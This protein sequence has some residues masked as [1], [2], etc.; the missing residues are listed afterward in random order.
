MRNLK[1]VNGSLW[2]LLFLLLMNFH[3]LKYGL[4]DFV[5][6]KGPLPMT[7]K[8]FTASALDQQVMLTWDAHEGI[9][10][11]LYHS[12][13]PGI[14]VNDKNAMKMSDVTSPYIHKELMHDTIYYYRL[15]AVN[16]VGASE[17]TEEISATT[18]GPG[19]PPPAPQN[20]MA[21]VSSGQVILTWDSL[22]S[23]TYDI[24]HSTNAGF[25]LASG[26]K[27]TNV[28]QPYTHTGLTNGTTYYYRLTATNASGTSPPTAEV[29]ATPLA[30]PQN[31]ATSAS[32]GQVMLTWDSLPGINY[33]I[34]HS[35]NA[36]FALASG[37]KITNAPQPYNHTGLTNGTTY[38][39]RLTATSASSTSPPTAEVSATPLA[40]PQNFTAAAS[41]GQVTLAWTEQ[42]GVTYDLYHST[43]TGFALANGIKVANAPQPYTHTGLT[44]GT[45]Y[46]YRLTATNAS[47][48]S[49]PTAE[50][51]AIPL[52][53]PQ[54]FAASASTG[55]VTLTWDSLP[56]VSYDLYHL[57]MS[58]FALV[59]G[60]KVANAPQPYTHTGLTNGTTYYYKL[61]VTSTLGTSSPTAEVSAT[62][63]AVPQNFAARPSLPGQI[64]L[65]WTEKEGVTYDLYHS[66]TAEFD[67][68][69]GI[70]IPNVPQP[71]TH[72]GLTDRTTYYYL[73]TAVNNSGTST[74]TA[75][76]SAPS[77]GVQKIS[78]GGKHTCAVIS[79]GFAEC[80]GEADSGRL[81]DNQSSS[82]RDSPVRVLGN[83]AAT[84][85]GFTQISAGEEHTCAV[86][87]GGAMCWGKGTSGRIGNSLTVNR[88][89]PVKTGLTS[90]V[91]RISAGGSHSCAVVNG[92]AMCWGLNDSGQLGN[93]MTGTAGSTSPVEV[94]DNTNTAITGVTQISAGD[95]HTCAVVNNKAWCWGEGDEGRLGNGQ[96]DDMN[97]PVLV[98]G[99]LGNVTQISAG[100]SH[101]CVVV[102]GRARCWGGGLRGQLGKGGDGA[103]LD[104]S[105]PVLVA[106]LTSGVTR[107]SAGGEHTCAV[108]NGRALCWGRGAGGQ[109][110]NGGTGGSET[111]VQV[112]GLTS[113]V[114]EI[115]AGNNHT[116]AVMNGRA[117][118]W[119]SGESGKL[120]DNMAIQRN[121]PVQVHDDLYD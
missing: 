92:G 87:N 62:P 106:G 73:L 59:N 7:P 112:S 86:V 28:P 49:R 117:L 61:T 44:N 120:G 88:N 37:T 5:N 74:P 51:S 93:P 101:T 21:R 84:I 17:P 82:D 100:G 47:G 32:T 55:Q 90:G 42:T 80:W 83:M 41:D 108:M 102:N 56:D 16:S 9:T 91:T 23:L 98:L 111:P 70:K 79:S 94:Q 35:T 19:E 34:Y 36:G 52:A 65:T 48:T 38:Y 27:I 75:E 116:C 121:T 2:F 115:S 29:S 68:A 8:N 89:F 14:D 50:V 39:Y 109:L 118:C 78:A 43:T 113:G 104:R 76:I 3:C 60:N 6:T 13:A 72:T 10:Y 4:G 66:T 67:L 33:D 11:D 1:N 96:T 25:A 26:I 97:F 24:Y 31:F 40:V 103:R 69:S 53:V 15:T 22:P 18:L 64:T 58:G 30:A 20:F 71:Y 114:T 63:L 77:G 57:T 46:Y 12:V 45:T 119:G 105:T 85:S 95:S 107:I 110:G 81:G 99:G 54:N